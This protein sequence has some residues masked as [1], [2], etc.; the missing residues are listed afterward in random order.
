MYKGIHVNYPLFLLDF[1]EI[2]NAST[3]IPKKKKT[4]KYQISRKSVGRE[5]SRSTRTD[6]QRESLIRRPPIAAFWKFANAPDNEEEKLPKQ[7]ERTP[8]W[9]SE[10]ITWKIFLFNP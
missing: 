8:I 6:G 5:P 1:Y 10:L 9:N 7:T 2:W 3:D 4:L